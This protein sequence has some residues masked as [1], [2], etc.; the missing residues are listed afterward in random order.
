MQNI[1]N[2][3]DPSVFILSTCSK[4]F[5]DASSTPDVYILYFQFNLHYVFSTRLQS[6][7]SPG[8]LH[9]LAASMETRSN[10]NKKLF[11]FWTFFLQS[12]SLF[13]F[14]RDDA[15]KDATRI[16]RGNSRPCLRGI[17]AD[18]R[19]SMETP[20]PPNGAFPQRPTAKVEVRMCRR[21]PEK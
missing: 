15:T 14:L 9:D 2:N 12:L 16:G 4:R 3:L 13:F 1:A 6:V 17:T 10:N 11:P 19:P 7:I 21:H 20:T 8:D 5:G 18:D